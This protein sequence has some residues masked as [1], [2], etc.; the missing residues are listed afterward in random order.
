MKNTLFLSLIIA[1][2][3][4][5]GLILIRQ[6]IAITGLR[7]E[8]A[9]AANAELSNDPV[10]GAGEPPTMIGPASKELRQWRR[11]V[12]ALRGKLAGLR[13][14]EEMWEQ[15]AGDWD[16][17]FGG[18]KP[19]DH[20]DFV[21]FTNLADVG[22]ATPDAAFQSFHHAFQNQRQQPI[23]NTL[24]KD[25]FDVPDDFDEPGGG[26]SINLGEGISGIGY[27]IVSRDPLAT[28]MVR[29]TFDVENRDGSW[30]RREKILIE[31]GGHWR[32]RPVSVTRP[33]SN[34]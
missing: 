5:A 24:M 9:Q 25:L 6:R 11:E 22:F 1:L 3:V 19:S 21:A 8:I 14:P 33:S 31:R 17:V 10:P 12:A 26:Y 32:V 15:S 13:E 23:T 7:T 28:N 18:P 4:L 30:S 16:L 29:L 34:Q 27:R 20:L 2:L